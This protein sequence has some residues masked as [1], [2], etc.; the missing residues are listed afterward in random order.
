MGQ[1]KSKELENF[2]RAAIEGIEKGLKN[3]YGLIGDI[4]FEV[5]VVKV[6]E[7]GARV[8]LFVVDASGKYEK[9]KVS[10]IKFKVCQDFP[11]TGGV[12]LWGEE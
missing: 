3:G 7:A 2:V 11:L 12:K 4:E 10:I 6:K 5:A 8:K 1:V 9:E